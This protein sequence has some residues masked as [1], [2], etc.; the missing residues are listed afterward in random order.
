[1]PHSDEGICIRG[2][3]FM[4]QEFGAVVSLN[5]AEFLCMV[6]PSEHLAL[7]DVADIIRLQMSI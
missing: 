1:M 2:M 3:V 4:N 6:S 7:P 5:G